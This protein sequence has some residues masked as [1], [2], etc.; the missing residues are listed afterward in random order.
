[1]LTCG[2]DEALVMAGCSVKGIMQNLHVV[3]FEHR[4]D[5]PSSHYLM[6]N[7]SIAETISD[8]ALELRNDN[9]VITVEEA[10]AGYFSLCVKL[11]PGSWQCGIKTIDDRILEGISDPLGLIS[12][13]HHF[14]TRLISPGLM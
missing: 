6:M 12:M 14:R 13:A 3:S 11:N 7:E 2:L 10:Q 9:Q 4:V 8:W 1:M 5:G